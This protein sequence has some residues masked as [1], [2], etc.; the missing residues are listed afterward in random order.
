MKATAVHLPIIL[1]CSFIVPGVALAQGRA[2]RPSDVWQGV[3]IGV[4]AGRSGNEDEHHASDDRGFDLRGNV[5]LP[6]GDRFVARIEAGRVSWRYDQYG[7]LHQL[8]DDRVAVK[9]VSAALLLVTDPQKPVLGYIGGGFSLYH[10]G[11]RV[12]SID[13]AFQRGPTFTMGLGVPVRR[14]EWAVTGDLQVNV[15]KTPNRDSRPGPESPVSGSA[16]LSLTFSLGV[17]K[18]F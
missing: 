12:G 9:R 6:L 5:D 2:I 13:A 1:A 11:A 14:R 3:S 10:W 16:V 18:Y 7:P 4:S 8:R 17:R 15:I